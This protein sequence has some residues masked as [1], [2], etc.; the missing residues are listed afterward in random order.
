MLDA[1]AKL[2]LGAIALGLVSGWLSMEQ[3]SFWQ[4][5][6]KLKPLQAS[7]W[8]NSDLFT[9][10][11]SE[12]NLAVEQKVKNY[13]QTLAKQGI[14]PA[15]QGIWIQSGWSIWGNSQG[16]TPLPAA[17]LT[18]IATTLAA[19]AKWGADYQFETRVYAHGKLNQGILVGDLIIEGSGDP[20]FVWEEAIA[21]GN[22]LNQLGIRQV[23]G[24]LVVTDNFYM[25]YEADALTAARLLKQALDRQLWQAEIK[26]QHTQLPPHT[27]RPQI[28]ITGKVKVANS[29]PVGALSLIRHQSLPLAEI[30]RQ[31][32]IYSNNYMAQMLADLLGGAK[33]VAR[34]ATEIA[35]I[36]ASEIQL[37]NGSGLGEDNRLSPRAVILMLITSDRLLQDHGYQIS[38]LFPVSGRDKVGTIQE[39]AI[40]PGTTIKTGT[41]ERVSSLAGA[42]PTGDRSNVWFAIINYGNQVEYLRQQQDLL[43]QEL[44]QDWQL[45]GDRNVANYQADWYLGDPRRNVITVEN[46]GQATN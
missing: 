4:Q 43:L 46:I 25:N 30:L 34:Q 37:V 10:P 12:S 23:Q 24:N 27:P 8:E 44:S 9:I 22:A 11:A 42:I 35:T 7:G 36:P 41:L 31:M 1:I 32:N 20:L 40:P 5:P 3:F 39:R 16:K 45:S 38:D 17:S 18:K 28:T 13:L 14:E 33:E 19:L 21:L 26:Q 6:A 2:T 15:Q 29:V